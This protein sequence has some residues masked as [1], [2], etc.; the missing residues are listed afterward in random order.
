[1][2][3]SWGPVIWKLFHTL[4]EKV[5][6]KDYY[7][8]AKSLFLF[9][10]RI[11]SLLPCPECQEHASL[12]LRKTSFDISTKQKLKQYL[13]V[14]HNEVNKRKGKKVETEEILKSYESEDLA[15]VYN[16]FV[17]VFSARGNVRM[18]ADTLHRQ[19]LMNEFR[20][21]IISQRECFH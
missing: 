14:F 11:C 10:K 16:D 13:L 3:N 21:W 12:Y 20:T 19:M 4:A 17:R 2:T 1:M 18:L 7:K 8:V 15:S 5:N 9:I 6:E